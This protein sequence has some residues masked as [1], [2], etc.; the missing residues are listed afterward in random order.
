MISKSSERR[1]DR[2][3]CPYAN[4]VG[5]LQAEV[6][7]LQIEIEKLQGAAKTTA[8]TLLEERAENK[9]YW[10]GIE[11]AVRIVSVILIASVLLIAGKFT[12]AIEFVLKMM[13]V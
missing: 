10:R 13:K 11:I 12:G 4:D 7:A 6:M 3:I 8:N 9:G 2:K 1:D 5:R